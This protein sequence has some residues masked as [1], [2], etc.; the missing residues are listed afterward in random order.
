MLIFIGWRGQ[1][2]KKDEPQH[3]AIGKQM[4]NILQSLQIKYNI[5][6]DYDEG[7]DNSI[8]TA[9]EYMTKTKK[10]YV[11]IVSKNT[12][13]NYTLVNYIDEKFQ[14]VFSREQLLDIIMNN[15]NN[16]DTIVSTTGML[17][18]ELYEY[19]VINNQPT[20]D[21][22]NVGSMGH[23]SSIALG[24]SLVNKDKNVVVF[25]GD[26]SVIMHM[27]SVAVNGCTAGKILNT[28]Y[29]IMVCMIQS[30]QKQGFNVFRI[31]KGV[32]L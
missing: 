19:R 30:G 12:F 18:R 3:F 5:L 15:I 23:C 27:G 6:P 1:P 7:A 8:D 17:S 26:G 9:V 2:G 13:S 28:S 29:L 11:F 32:Q 16:T 4:E 10:P 21:I 24:L 20:K 14:Y 22:L 25:D 31:C